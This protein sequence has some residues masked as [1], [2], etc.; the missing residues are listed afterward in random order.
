M[1]SHIIYILFVIFSLTGFSQ[2]GTVTGTVSDSETNEPLPGVNVVV[3]NTTIGTNTDFDGNFSIE[4]VSSGDVLVFSYLGFKTQEITVGDASNLD[5]SLVAD[6]E[7]LDEVIVLGYV[8]QKA[9]NISGSVSTVSEEQVQNLKPVRME[10]A[11][12]GLPGVNM[13]S[14][15]APGAKPNVIIRGVT[16]YTGNAPLVIVDGITLSLDDMN[17]LDPNDIKSISVLKDAS[18]TAL[19][20]VRGGNGVIVITTKSGSRNQD[21]KY[22]FNTSYGQQSP[23]KTIGVLNATEYAAILNEMSVNSGGPLILSLIHI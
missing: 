3:K 12:Q 21:A 7:A 10:D 2:N 14:N 20:G 13:F 5:V 1:K 18:T 17:A 4:G 15:G 6:A 23:E 9:A 8:S 11:L 19:Y 22:S 16:S